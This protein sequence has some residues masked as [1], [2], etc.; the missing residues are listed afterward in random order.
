MKQKVFTTFLE[1]TSREEFIPKQGFSEKMEIRQVNNDPFFNHMFFLGVGLPWEWYSRLS[2]TPRDWKEHFLTKEVYTYLA[3][4]GKSLAGYFE[5]EKSDDTAMEI[6]YIGLLPQYTGK[7]LG[8]YLISHAVDKAFR[9]GVKRVWLHTCN[10]DHPHA[11]RSYKKRGFS[12]FKETEENEDL[13]DREFFLDEIRAYFESY[14]L[15]NL[16]DLFYPPCA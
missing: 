14:L 1:I 3:F 9:F 5:L 7:G 12:T 8:G 4:L 16:R 10:N 13:P 15:E 2:W 6:K 11:I